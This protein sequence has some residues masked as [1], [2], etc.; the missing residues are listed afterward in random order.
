MLCVICATFQKNVGGSLDKAKKSL[1]KGVEDEVKGKVGELYKKSEPHKADVVGDTVGDPFKG[2]SCPSMNILI[3]LSCLVGLT[4]APTLG[5][6]SAAKHIETI[7]NK[8]INVT[9]V[10]NENGVQSATMTSSET[11]PTPSSVVEVIA[12]PGGEQARVTT[13]TTARLADGREET[14][15]KSE[16]R[17]LT[18][19]EKSRMAAPVNKN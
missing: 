1:E 5:D 12:L 8:E 14:T 18:A 13:T 15:T 17:S 3:K 4:L 6:H 10:S 2:T 19:E 16:V 11:T 7:L 9:S